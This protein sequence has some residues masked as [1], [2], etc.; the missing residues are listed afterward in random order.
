MVDKAN[1]EG[2]YAEGGY[3]PNAVYNND[4]ANAAIASFGDIVG[5]ALTKIKPKAEATDGKAGD[6]KTERLDKKADRLE[7]RSIKT[8]NKKQE[9][10]KSGNLNKAD[11]MNKRGERLENRLNN[12]NNRLGEYKE[13]KGFSIK[14][15]STASE[16]AKSFDTFKNEDEESKEIM[17]SIGNQF[18]NFWRR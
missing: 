18:G 4:A 15:G 8:E 2:A 6:A 11:R 9:A 3:N 14:S 5:D 17:K 7:R 1:E 13:R 12:T 10:L 16:D